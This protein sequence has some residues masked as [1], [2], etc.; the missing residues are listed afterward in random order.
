MWE[1][2]IHNTRSGSPELQLPLVSSATWTRRLGS[3][4]SGSHEV[5]L[6]HAQV[7]KS[8]IREI[9]RGNKYTVA[10]RWG[11][12]CAYAG[13]ITNRRYIDRSS[14]LI[15]N[16]KELRA[17]VLGARLPHGVNE[18]NAAAGQRRV[19]DKSH[20]GALRAV[21]SWATKGGTVPGWELPI[22]L[23]ADAA[24]GFS[25]T[26]REEEGLTTNDLIEQI[27]ED[28]AET[29]LHPYITTDGYLRYQAKA[30]A[31]KIA[32][33]GAFLLPARAPGS[34]VLDLE[35][36][37]DYAE[38]MTGVLGFGNGTGQDRL[39]KFA[40]TSGDGIGDLPVRDVR[41]NFPDLYDPARLQAAVN[42][43]YAQ[44][45]PPIDQWSFSLYIGGIGPTFAAPTHLLDMH[46]YGSD[47]IND[48]VHTK[49]VIALS[50]DM[51]LIVKPEVQPHG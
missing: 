39:S 43:E 15:L 42:A 17:A 14:R 36:E 29:D 13:V 44:R 21:L 51:G 45:R 12:E 2:W 34:I 19:T 33:A 18:Y 22:D 47:F 3:L 25:A 26:W 9:S 41:V 5:E 50:G 8:L 46:V 28:G 48:G 4:G 1:V 20:A 27:E 32:T 31:V 38:Q 6:S 23:P 24:G 11:V 10:Q 7:P 35:T 49:R 30:A 40:P 16:H 37:E